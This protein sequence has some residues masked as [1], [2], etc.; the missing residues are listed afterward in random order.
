MFFRS[1]FYERTIFSILEKV[2]RLPR[3]VQAEIAT[4]VNNFIDHA[5]RT[6]EKAPMGRLLEAARREREKSVSNETHP[7]LEQWAGPALAEGWCTAM[8]GLSEGSM[9]RHCAIA[10]IV[11]IQT[12]ATKS[13]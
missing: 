12:F 7:T 13:K 5:K 6:G 2:E 11:A 1:L 9:D 3:P 8:L 4:R 10:I